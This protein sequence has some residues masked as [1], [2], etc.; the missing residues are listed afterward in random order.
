MNHDEVSC[1]NYED[2]KA[3][4]LDYV[5]QD[6]L[7]TA[8]SYARFCKTIEEFTGL[9]CKHFNSVRDEND[10][11]IYIYDDK[12]IRLFVRR[13]VNRRRVCS[14]NQYLKSNY[15]DDLLKIIS[16]ELNVK[17]KIYDVIEAY[18]NYKIKHFKIYEKEYAN[19]IND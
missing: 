18:L 11:P 9:C 16:E 15:C 5:K 1:S 10:E 2:K 17:E 3:E 19:N 13:S 6:A 14:F 12:Y 7:C 8:F 4:W